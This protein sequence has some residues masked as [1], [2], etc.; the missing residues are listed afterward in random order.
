M[1]S[2]FITLL[3][4]L[5]LGKSLHLRDFNDLFLPH[6]FFVLLPLPSRR[7]TSRSPENG[8]RKGIGDVSFLGKFPSFVELPFVKTLGSRGIYF[9]NIGVV[10]DIPKVGLCFQQSSHT[11]QKIPSIICASATW[12]SVSFINPHDRNGKDTEY[13]TPT[14]VLFNV[15]YRHVLINR[16][17]EHQRRENLKIELHFDDR[18][19]APLRYRKT[20]QFKS[21]IVC[22]FWDSLCCIPVCQ[23]NCTPHGLSDR[24]C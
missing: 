8:H 2:I 16:F 20:K 19:G 6:R 7:L 12:S 4:G 15:R 23:R 5:L 13:V 22:G 24:Y 9:S 3:D 10:L 11:V 1:A 14:H 18:L 21:M 17:V